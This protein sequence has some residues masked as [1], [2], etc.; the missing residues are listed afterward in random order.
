MDGLDLVAMPGSFLPHEHYMA[1]LEVSQ[2]PK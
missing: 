1:W 2:V